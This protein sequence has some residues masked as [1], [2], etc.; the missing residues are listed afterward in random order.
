ML[1]LMA[2]VTIP[3]MI[4]VSPEFLFFLLKMVSFLFLCVLVFCLNARQCEGVRSPGSRVID[5]CQLPYRC[6]E[7]IPGLLNS[8][9][10]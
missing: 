1:G 10:S 4:R 7:L 5:H 6:W 8:L 9:C 2:C 3:G